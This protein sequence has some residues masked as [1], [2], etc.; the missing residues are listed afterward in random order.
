MKCYICGKKG[1]EHQVGDMY[2]CEKCNKTHEAG[3]MITLMV[4]ERKTQNDNKTR[5]RI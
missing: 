4:E 5:G 2:L 3:I 1:A